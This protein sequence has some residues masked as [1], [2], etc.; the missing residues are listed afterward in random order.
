MYTPVQSTCNLNGITYWSRFATIF[1]PLQVDCIEREV[2]DFLVSAYRRSRR[3]SPVAIQS[4]TMAATMT[5]DA[6]RQ[7]QKKPQEINEHAAPPANQTKPA[8]MKLLPK[9]M[10]ACLFLLSA[11]ASVMSVE[12]S[13]IKA[14]AEWELELIR[15]WQGIDDCSP[16]TGI[17]DACGLGVAV[18]DLNGPGGFETRV[19]NAAPG[20]S[21]NNNDENPAPWGPDNH[22][23]IASITKPFTAVAM[24]VLEDEGI[25]SRD[26]TIG[27]L[28]PC[29][30]DEANSNV[31]SITLLEMVTHSSGLPAQPPDRGP[32]IAGNPF[33]NYTEER[34]CASLLK[35]NG[36]PTRGRYSY[37]NYAYGILGYALTLAIDPVNPPP[38][39]DVIKRTILVPLEMRNTSVTYDEAGWAEA[40]VGCAR[41][42]NRAKETIR[43]GAYGVIQGNGALR[44]TLNDVV[45]FLRLMLYINAGSPMPYNET[46][47]GPAHPPSEALTRLSR[48]LSNEAMTG[49]KDLACS[50]VS[51]WCEGYLCPIPNP[52]DNL[53]ITAGGWEGYTSGG[54]TAW[55][56]S[57]DTGGYSSRVAWSY[58]KG[59]AAVAADTCGGCGS[60]GTAGSGPQRAALLLVDG[61]PEDLESSTTQEIPAIPTKK[62]YVGTFESHN[63]PSL[64]KIIVE[65]TPKDET[66]AEIAVSSSDGAGGTSNASYAGDGVWLVHDAVLFGTGWGKSSDP[67]TGLA[68]QR[69]LIFSPDG[70]TATF[71]DLGA[72]ITKLTLAADGN[73]NGVAKR[74]DETG[75]GKKSSGAKSGL[76][77]EKEAFILTLLAL[78]YTF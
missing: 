28:L 29:N 58:E 68:Q 24:L 11:A 43:L 37:S 22:W 51:D 18:V 64:S 71:Q 63:F 40:A 38:Y 34:L 15:K 4:R 52:S 57:G 69:A 54:A 9:T 61:P 59:R 8:N 32:T 36:L 76:R 25:V 47:F 3:Q 55:K 77:H 67:F 75:G 33:G 74:D 41:G 17:C 62:T 10:H 27:E 7:N 14:A 16:S 44:S 49:G 26:A 5:P 73:D 70:S 78:L 20:S 50:C 65:V 13:S 6:R 46:L 30:W 48:V 1:P 60:V 56:K 12:S 31:A 45:E 21:A 39:E 2:F 19:Y 72:D 53:I 66:F 35:L 23:E 42:I